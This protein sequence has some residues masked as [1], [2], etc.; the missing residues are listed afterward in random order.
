[1]PRPGL[2]PLVILCDYRMHQDD[3]TPNTPE[4]RLGIQGHLSYTVSTTQPRTRRHYIRRG[5]GASGAPA[6]G[7]AAH[8]TAHN[9][10]VQIIHSVPYPGA[11][12]K[13]KWSVPLPVQ[14]IIVPGRGG[15]V[16]GQCPAPAASEAGQV[17]PTAPDLEPRTPTHARVITTSRSSYISYPSAVPLRGLQTIKEVRGGPACKPSQV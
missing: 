2:W 15:T 8:G 12:V 11:Q 13:L 9:S 14:Q 16:A 3:K 7:T 17:V 1:M 6:A 10:N 5:R 4:S